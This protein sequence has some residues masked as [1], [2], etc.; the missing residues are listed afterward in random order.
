MKLVSRPRNHSKCSKPHAH[1]MVEK[2]TSN[3]FHILHKDSD[4]TADYITKLDLKKKK[5]TA[6]LE[7]LRYPS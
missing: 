5:P 7:S 4:Y 2:K 6:L 1:T 3:I